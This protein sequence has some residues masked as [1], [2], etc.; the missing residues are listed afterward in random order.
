[1]LTIKEIENY[2]RNASPENIEIVLELRNLI[3]SID[4]D[5]TEMI[6]WKGIS[7]FD[8]TRGG[9]VSAGICQVHI[10]EGVVRLG[11]IHG[12]FLADP[13]HLLKGSR[14][15]KRYLEIPSYDLAPWEEIKSLIQASYEFDP[16]SLKL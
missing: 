14:K 11:F 4:P 13:D 12:A 1:M 3:F 10:I 2:F 15:V 5:A 7:Y 16:Y 6:Q 9:T 8:A